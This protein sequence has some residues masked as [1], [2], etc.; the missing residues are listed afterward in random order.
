[1]PTSAAHSLQ[2]GLVGQEA[3][4]R[5]SELPP[6]AQLDEMIDRL[7]VLETGPA[8]VF[9]PVVA[10]ASA[11]LLFDCTGQ[12]EP[13]LSLSLSQPLPSLLPAGLCL[14]GLR[15]R[16]GAIGRLLQLPVAALDGLL[17]AQ[18]SLPM[19]AGWPS[20]RRR[21]SPE[22]G[23]E[24]LCAQLHHT[25]VADSEQQLVEAALRRLETEAAATVAS[26][27]GLSERHLRRLLLQRAGLPP[28]RYQ[29]VRR[30]QR[31]LA[32]LAASPSTPLATLAADQGYSD[33]T[34][35]GHDWLALSGFT[36]GRWRGRFLQETPR[37]TA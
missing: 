24:Q 35:L 32:V 20:R 26:V 36:P 8:P 21:Q 14:I 16:P 1:M 7:Y 2:P 13:L 27:L 4:V 29:R 6:P 22:R 23:L 9:Y 28:K 10:D 31:S 5:Y 37:T 25:A 33:Q 15:L 30:F 12:H 3:G 17:T 11:D 34:H 18:H 19:P